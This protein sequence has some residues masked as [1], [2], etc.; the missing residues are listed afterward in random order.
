MAKN[1]SIPSTGGGLFV[2]FPLTCRFRDLQS[3]VNIHHVKA[4]WF[5]GRSRASDLFSQ[6]TFAFITA[7]L[8][9]EVPISKSKSS[10][11]SP[12]LWSGDV[13]A[14]GLWDTR[15]ALSLVQ[16][17]RFRVYIKLD[18]KEW[19]VTAPTY[20]Y[21]CPHAQLHLADSL[22]NSF[23]SSV[24][25]LTWCCVGA[26]CVHREVGAASSF[27]LLLK[28]FSLTVVIK[29]TQCQRDHIEHLVSTAFIPLDLSV[30][31]KWPVLGGKPWMSARWR[32]TCMAPSLQMRLQHDTLTQTWRLRS[33]GWVSVIMCTQSFCVT[34]A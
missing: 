31:L 15:W 30:D 14:S 17:T 4:I 3:P 32:M 16:S 18:R 10:K 28:L 5:G 8:F 11:P 19:K 27:F 23:F 29:C 26:G 20:Y 25:P 34:S 24:A 21:G 1:V 9:P 33:V 22:W 12:Q 2:S 6:K 13:W 7:Y